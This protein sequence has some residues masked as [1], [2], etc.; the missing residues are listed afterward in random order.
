MRFQGSDNTVVCGMRGSG[1]SHF[2]RAVVKATPRF[3]LW[4][5]MHEH[6]S[7]GYVVRTPDQLRPSLQVKEKI[8]YQPSS[9]TQ[10]EFEHVV[11]QVFDAGNRVLFVDE[12]DQ[13]IPSRKI[14][15]QTKQFIDLGRHRNVG[16][17]CVTRRLAA[18]DKNPLAQAHHIVVFKTILPTD[19]DYLREFIGKAADQAPHLDGHRFLLFED[20]SVQ[21]YE[22]I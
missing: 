12:A 10:D 2:L 7:L 21:L 11:K 16:M 20:G 13:V 18:L 1:K 5:Y 6:G 9:R 4:D 15:F 19:V 3:V 22:K 14:G 17:F 8:V